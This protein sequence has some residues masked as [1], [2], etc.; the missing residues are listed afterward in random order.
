MEWP[1]LLGPG[2]RKA[3]RKDII[4]KQQIMNHAVVNSGSLRDRHGDHGAGRFVNTQFSQSPVPLLIRPSTSS[5]FYEC[6]GGSKRFRGTYRL[7]RL[8]SRLR[9]PG[10]RGEN[11]S[12]LSVSCGS[13]PC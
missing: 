3:N 5:G 10:K 9:P 12:L 6:S 8:C 7:S 13:G 4:K 2:R 1:Q 11:W